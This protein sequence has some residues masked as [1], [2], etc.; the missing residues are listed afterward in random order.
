MDAAAWERLC[1][2]L[3]DALALAP[4][5]RQ[6]EVERALADA[7]ELVAEA[8]RLLAHEA[9]AERLEPG[10]RAART[11][12][13]GAGR[14]LGPWRIE[15]PLGSGGM[16]SVH[17]VVRDA[18]GLRAALKLLHVG[19]ALSPAGVRRFQSERR[20]LA[21]LDH[22]GIARLIDGGVTEDGLP[23]LVLEYVEGR[24]LD[25]FARE[26]NL[27]VRA[28]VRLFRGVCAAVAYAHRH[29]I[30]HRDL[31]PAN[32]VVD[33]SGRARLLDFGIAKL[34]DADETDEITHTGERP[35]TPRYASPE[36]V[37]GEPL[38]TAS[39]VYSLGVVL[40][41]LLCGV[42]PYADAG[43]GPEL[44][45][46]VRDATPDAPS[47]AVGRSNEGRSP[48]DAR[49]L[50]RQ[51]AGDLDRIVLRALAKEPARRYAGAAELDDDLGRWLDGLPVRARP[52]SALYRLRRFAA[53]HR[54]VLVASVALLASLAAGV[55]A[56][57]REARLARAAERSES[58]ARERAERHFDRARA[59]I[60]DL[61]FGVHDRIERL[62]GATPARRFA[63][64]RARDH[65]AALTDDAQLRVRLGPELAATWMRLAQV[66]G[67]RTVGSEGD[68]AAAL[69][70]TRRARDLYAA[71]L[72]DAPEDL[73]RID[74]LCD[75][76]RQL[77]DLVR[78]A[79]DPRTALERYARV[80]EVVAQGLALDPTHAGLRRQRALAAGQRGRILM[81]QSHM[82]EARDELERAIALLSA[83]ASGAPER[84]TERDL[85]LFELRLAECESEL[86]AHERSL[87]LRRTACARAQRLALAEPLDAQL[88]LDAAAAE[89][90][91]AEGL[92]RMALL[93]EAEERVVAAVERLRGLHAADPS[94]QLPRR[95]LLSAIESQGAL[96]LELGRPERALEHFEEARDLA[97]AGLAGSRGDASTRIDLARLETVLGDALWAFEDREQ[98]EACFQRAFDL[99]GEAGEGV[100]ARRVRFAAQIGM[101][102]VTARAGRT[103]E[104]FDLLEQLLELAARDRSAHP[105]SAWPLRN[106]ALAG[107]RLAGLL[108]VRGADAA[109][110]RA[111]RVDPLL[112]ARELF[113]EGRDLAEDMARRGWLTTL[114]RRKD[115]A[116]LFAAD[117]ERIDR[118]LVELGVDPD[119]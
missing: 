26:E 85:S 75:A 106:R 69:E 35:M 94:N 74:D 39:D 22:P 82:L 109:R 58:A 57:A 47:T 63:L 45:R 73:E 112:R 13:P 38:S 72:D 37:R 115:V 93:D 89:V 29:L 80:E 42:S 25:R 117:V 98:A 11:N 36:Q 76:E 66:Q 12:G 105:D 50:R 102:D 3:A 8:R 99:L 92:R 84:E 67:T 81:E 52:D 90:D 2:V 77:G 114:E 65:L 116:A 32:I 79:G 68:V 87:D 113:A 55:A 34:L 54:A 15:A 56:T 30:V 27:D 18:D 14:L 10:A 60:D 44:E 100:E 41:E 91:L 48:I 110:S 96:A 101:A 108:E 1:D 9:G 83:S 118:A 88:A 104:A 111:E 119:S 24:A 61:V 5:A 16:G 107:W 97:E 4:D 53:R 40:Y 33:A 71:A 20:L 103:Q 17:L 70:S 31:K 95:R 62:P 49:R 43:A 78:E 7:P 21:R 51:L 28:R 19:L 86:G 64:E 23:Y 6:A 46:A 59:L